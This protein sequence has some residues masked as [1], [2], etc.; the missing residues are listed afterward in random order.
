MWE[1]QQHKKELSLSLSLSLDAFA[2]AATISKVLYNEQQSV[3]CGG[4]SLS[5]YPF[6]QGGSQSVKTGSN[7]VQ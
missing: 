5:F 2:M 1:Q 3:E 4:F 6:I 7:P